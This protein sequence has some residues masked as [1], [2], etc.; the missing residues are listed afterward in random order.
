[1]PVKKTQQIPEL[2]QCAN[3]ADELADKVS[4]VTLLAGP[5]APK[6]I[7]SDLASQLKRTEKELHFIA[8]R[9]RRMY[10][11]DDKATQTNNYL[12]LDGEEIRPAT[13]DEVLRQVM[14]YPPRGARVLDLLNLAKANPQAV[15]RE[16]FNEKEA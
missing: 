11:L 7:T 10:I 5:D 16:V 3:M 15:I 6:E 14:H 12:I 8:K 1:M 9:L 2:I 13:P 4:C